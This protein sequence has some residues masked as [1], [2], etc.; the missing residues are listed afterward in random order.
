MSDPA[1][2]Q[3]NKNCL[4]CPSYLT[5]NR[6]TQ[7]YGRGIGAAVC[8]RHG[9]VLSKPG[10]T[11]EQ[12]SKLT[13]AKA[14]GCAE[15]GQ[16]MPNVVS[17]EHAIM[18][19]DPTTRSA[20]DPN[21]RERTGCTSCAM[22]VNSIPDR[23]VTAE[24]GFTATLCAAKGKLIMSTRLTKE[25]RDC[26]FRRFGTVRE[27]IGG[28][29]FFAE[30]TNDF[31]DG[32]AAAVAAA[33]EA[34]ENLI[35]PGEY[36]TDKEVS[37]EDAALGIKA[38]RRFED[39]DGSGN[40]VFFPVYDIK[41]FSDA[42]QELVPK[43]GSDDHPELYVDHFGGMY[44]LGVAWMELD[45]TPVFWGE[46]GVGKTELLR[47]A[48]WVMQVPFRR[49]S[50]TAD[51]DID[52]IAGKMQFSPDDGTYFEMGRVPKAWISPGV[53]CLDEPN[54]A[55]DPAVW[56]FIR[57]MTDNSKQLVMDLWD[58]RALD[59]HQDCYLGMAMNPAWDIRNIGALEIADA[60]ANRLV[61]TWIPM[62]PKALEIEIIKA[63]VAL[64]GWELSNSQINMLMKIAA[65]LRAMSSEAQLPITWAIRQQ[66]KV[67]RLLKWYTPPV[68]YRRAAGDYLDPEAQR[69]LAD[70]VN[71][72]WSAGPVPASTPAPLRP[73]RPR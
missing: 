41:S 52:D 42:D 28:M 51:S 8:A 35:E 22:C 61:H 53:L 10:A 44:G 3:P 48:A 59:R 40:E 27:S 68:A 4:H 15:Y 30:Y 7:V 12:N 43:T 9:H 54:V 71:A 47:H 66:I 13:A 58:G 64:D 31:L 45:E 70:A 1:T 39:P 11:A 17:N 26:E 57:P 56:H 5:A 18:L 46:P 21:D 50:I 62:P 73:S 34:R 25:A 49:I 29:S 69:M 36:E 33:K 32:T 23:V 6:V 20:L 60:D 24:L 67:A 72:H 63:R 55:K 19:P 38:Y 16:P 14:S 65:D 37:P 2:A